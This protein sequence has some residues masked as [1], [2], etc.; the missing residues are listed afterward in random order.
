M[1]LFAGDEIIMP[2]S[3]KEACFKESMAKKGWNLDGSDEA[4]GEA[5]YKDGEFVITTY[6]PVSIPDDLNSFKES[7][8]ECVRG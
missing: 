8:F 3:V 5:G 4:R 7:A 1:P 2:F 6:K